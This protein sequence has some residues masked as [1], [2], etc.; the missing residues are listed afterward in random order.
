MLRKFVM[1]AML[2]LGFAGASFTAGSAEA[3]IVQPG[4]G[5]GVAALAASSPDAVTK[6]W[7]YGR[8]HYRARYY[9][10]APYRYARPYRNCRIVS[11]RVWTQ[12]GY[13]TVKRSVCY[14]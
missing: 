14:R 9:R 3:A 12:Y 6:V 7:H 5:A 4:A 2:A 10:P 1:A 11:R 8:P 13:R